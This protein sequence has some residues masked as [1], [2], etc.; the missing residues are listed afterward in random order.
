MI[1]WIIL[2]FYFQKKG[3]GHK[4]YRLVDTSKIKK[5]EKDG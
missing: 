4:S 3:G 2:L 1:Q 5:E